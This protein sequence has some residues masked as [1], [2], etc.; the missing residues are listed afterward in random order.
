[1]HKRIVEPAVAAEADLFARQVVAAPDPRAADDELLVDTAGQK[2]Q[3]GFISKVGPE[4]RRCGHVS[5]V[6]FTGD[7]AV[8]DAFGSAHEARALYNKTMLVK[9]AGLPGYHHRSGSL[10]DR[11]KPGVDVY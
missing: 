7:E 10:A 1:L 6:N 9:Q 3:I 11:G 8:H 2:D 5:E 4:R